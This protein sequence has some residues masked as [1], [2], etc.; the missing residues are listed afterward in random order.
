MSGASGLYPGLVDRLV[1]QVAPPSVR[2]A[3]LP[4]ALR[5][6]RLPA[7]EQ[8]PPRQ[9][10]YG[11]VLIRGYITVLVAPGGV[12]KTAWTMGCACSL[13]IGRRL[14]DDWVYQKSRVLVCT[15]EDPEEEF[16]RRLAAVRLHYGIP[17]ADLDGQVYVVSGR[18]RRLLVAALSEDGFTVCYPDKDELVRQV[19][20][21]GIGVVI[22]DP[23]VNSHELDENNNPHIN[24]AAR[25]W[26]EIA[27]EAGCAVLL[28][29]HTRKG[30]GAGDIE[31]SRGAKALTD[32]CR[33]GLTLSP[34]TEDE[35]A[36][37]G[38]S[39]QERR[40]HVRLDDA[41]ANLSPPAAKA[42]WFKLAGVP[43][44]NG[45]PGT[46]WHEGDNVQAIEVWTPPET[47]T[48]TPAELNRALDL[49]AAGPGEGQLYSAR[50][51]GAGAGA[52]WCGTP[53]V[54]ALG[55]SEE[56]AARMVKTWLGN[57]LL[58]EREY[59]DPVQRKK[60]QGVFVVNSR[61]PS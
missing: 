13:A 55:V 5:P 49:I 59:M 27:N 43:L 56:Q 12:G 18:D 20:A 32:A 44:N 31:G 2:E 9:W 46:P 15:L 30:A 34:M 19:K 48:H 60:R 10:L 1:R 29:H 16:D 17:D 58:E 11:R 37:F 41:K 26:A 42:R 21:A 51:S 53:L 7:P 6:A 61:R 25:A 28:V 33:V 14:T 24:A 4:L 23:F 38:I 40:L 8:I 39:L 47:W 52:R 54:E 3:V 22:V 36:G 35:A 57:K 50:R 45:L